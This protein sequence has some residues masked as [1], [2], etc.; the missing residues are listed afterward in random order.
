MPWQKVVGCCVSSNNIYSEKGGL[1]NQLV[2]TIISKG[3]VV[4][5][6]TIFNWLSN[7]MPATADGAADSE[8]SGARAAGILCN[9]S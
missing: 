4:L 8:V 3:H 9:L 5:K 1:K 7:Y 6:K 2:Q